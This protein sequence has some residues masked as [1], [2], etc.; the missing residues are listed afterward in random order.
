MATP[1]T[2]SPR[3]L[4][5]HVPF[6][7]RRCAYCDFSI[8]VRRA[9]PIDEYV[10]G[11]ER[12]LRV[13]FGSGRR[14]PLE[15]LYLGG[16]TPSRLGGDGVARLLRTIG[17]IFPLQPEAELT[18]EA[19]PEDVNPDAVRAWRAA[20]VNRLS[21]GA[22]SFD[23]GVLKW[24]HRV[25]D[26]DAIGKAVE[27]ARSGGVTNLSLDL[28]FAL[29][30]HLHRDWRSDLRSALA[31]SPAHVSLYGLTIEGRTPLGRWVAR[32]EAVE[33]P[34][35][36]YEAE[37][38]L[39]HRALTTAGFDHYEVSNFAQPG[40]RSRHNS[41]YWTGVAYVG[42]GP[43]AHEY[44]GGGVRRWNAR[45]YAEWLA[46]VREGSDPVEDSEVLTEENRTAESVYLGLRTTGGLAMVRGENELVAPWVAAG[47]ATIAPGPRLVLTPL[48]WL[49]LD[50]LAQS[51][52]LR[53]SR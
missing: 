19:N 7:T 25:H 26:S 13:R 42:I 24:M 45:A 16:G 1:S 43:A 37:F 4:Y 51:L 3:H 40:C 20:G 28:I 21:I 27:H 11:I 8:A 2:P 35:E 41:A 34:E 30:D 23:D 5:V 33:A 47:W 10:D 6:C 18:L 17:R 31:L 39:A 49:R 44:D 14:E 38:L 52:T 22:Q 12:E 50:S 32:G 9:V 48:G 15:T 53:R 36:S 29:P 46:R